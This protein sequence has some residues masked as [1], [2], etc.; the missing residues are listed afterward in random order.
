[1]ESINPKISV[2]T[3]S[4]NQGKFL[5]Q[6][7]LSVISQCY[8]NLE[9][10]IMDGGSTDESVEI[11][12]KYEQHITYWQSKPDNGQAGAI[13]E[14]FKHA[15][16][17]IL[18][19][20]NS[21]D[22][23]MPGIFDRIAAIFAN[24]SKPAIV[25]GNCLHFNEHSSKTRGSDVVG[26]DA[27]HILSLYDYIIQ[28]SSFWNRAAWLATGALEESMHFAFDWD[29]FIRAQNT[30]V[31]FVPVQD[32][33]SIYRIHE[34]HKTGTGGDKRNEELK[35]IVSRYNEEQK[36]IRAFNRWLRIYAKY[37]FVSKIIESGYRFRLP[38]VNSLSRLFLFPRLSKKQYLSIVSMK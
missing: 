3:P 19:W 9:Y 27:R 29:W 25:F 38:V 36:L 4:Y 35:K 30:G 15:T 31:Q 23:Y 18:C 6:T 17:D 34:S 16:G 33:L 37:K 12:K 13:N 8:P 21:D 2:I 5:E 22:M 1:M 10:I 11:I 28:P 7:I 32:Y 14:G 24:T 20:L 26:D